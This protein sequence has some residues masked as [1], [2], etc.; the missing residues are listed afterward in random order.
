MKDVIDAGKQYP[1]KDAL[2]H[3]NRSKTQSPLIVIDPVDKSRNAAAALSLEKFQLLQKK[4]WEYLAR[5]DISFFEKKKIDLDVLKKEVESKKKNL[6][7]MS[8]IPLPG[9]EDV[10]GTKLVKV[11][12]FLRGKLASFLIVKSGWEWENGKEAQFYFVLAKKELPHMEIRTGP[13]LKLQEHV[14]HFKK[15]HKDT[16]VKEGKIYANVKVEYPRLDDF[17]KVLLK[18]K[19]L[20]EKM[21]K[22]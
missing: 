3:L 14:D 6:L 18:E 8:I 13:P 4:A 9:K 11:F 17:V 1:K 10:V 2:F 12:E 16:F 7:F 15:E 19:Y 5:P 20:L 21:K 22:V